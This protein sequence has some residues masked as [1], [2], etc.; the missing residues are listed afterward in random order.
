MRIATNAIL[1]K[2]VIE[3]VRRFEKKEIAACAKR[4]EFYLQGCV[5]PA[6]K[7][8]EL[9]RVR[10]AGVQQFKAPSLPDAFV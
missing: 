6:K 2:A 5:P 3:K 4:K 9:L 10:A 1:S 7:R 8:R